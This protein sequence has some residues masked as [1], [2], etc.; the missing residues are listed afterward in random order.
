[1]TALLT[2][3]TFVKMGTQ[4][5]VNVESSDFLLTSMAIEAAI[6]EVERIEQ[7][8]SR[9]RADSYLSAIN[10][11]GINGGSIALDEETLALIEYAAACHRLSEGRFDITSGILRRAWNFKSSIIPTQEQ[12]DV[13]LPDI[14]FE[15]LNWSESTLHI[16][17]G[18]ELDL[19]GVGKEYA[20]DRIAD[21]WLDMGVE[22]GLIDLGGDIRAVGSHA[23]GSPWRI[24][25]RDP[26]AHDNAIVTVELNDEA[27]ATS[28]DY[29]R[30]LE[31]D[32]KRYC[33]ILDPMTGWPVEGL[34]SVSV[35]A[36]E[37]MVAGSLSTIAMLRGAEGGAWLRSLNMRHLIVDQARNVMDLG[38]L[39]PMPA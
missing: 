30:Y 2:S 8:Y 23:D 7:H 34:A 11:C 10:T 20:V 22:H 26:R 35:I 12:I 21:I 16:P 38:V 32:G 31:I 27:L 9:Y 36:K 24:G 19:G 25:I 28:G 15:R 14:G 33:H 29:E 1:M 3:E 18:I 17:K 5:I 13:L 39:S 4:C 6:T 37:C